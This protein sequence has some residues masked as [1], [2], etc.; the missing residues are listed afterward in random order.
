[1]GHTGG[2]IPRI[3][4]VSAE[5]IG[6]ALG[7]WT[8]FIIQ[9]V[10]IEHLLCARPHFGIGNAVVDKTDIVLMEQTISKYIICSKGTEVGGWGRD[11][12]E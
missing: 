7:S 11:C 6:S 12:F 3:L 4:G 5:T 10:F 2:L 8:R 1:M 9:Q